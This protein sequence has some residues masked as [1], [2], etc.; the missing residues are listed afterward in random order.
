VSIIPRDF[1]TPLFADIDDLWRL[2]PADKQAAR[3]QALWQPTCDIKDNGDDSFSIHVEL[4]GVKKENIEIDLHDG[5]L[6]VKGKKES[7]SETKDEKGSL[8]AARALVRL[9]PA[10]LQSARRRR[11]QARARRLC[12]RCARHQGRQAE[13]GDAEASQDCCEVIGLREERNEKVKSPAR[14]FSPQK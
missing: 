9:L 1:F 4:P 5:A 7:A 14:L 12:G 6:T 3:Q 8:G 11:G 13:A 10:A 2:Q